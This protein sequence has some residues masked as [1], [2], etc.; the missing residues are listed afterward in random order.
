MTG[1]ADTNNV[2]RIFLQIGL[3]GV[4]FLPAFLYS[5]DGD[6][7]DPARQ[8]MA[9]VARGEV[10]AVQRDQG[11]LRLSAVEAEL[12]RMSPETI[13]KYFLTREKTLTLRDPAGLES[14][15]F[16]CTRVDVETAV[17]A[18]GPRAI[19]LTGIFQL[20]PEGRGRIT[21]GFMAGLYRPVPDYLPPIRFSPDPRRPHREIRHSV[22]HKIMI[23]V[24]DDFAVIGQGSDPESDNFNPYFYDRSPTVTPR[25]RAFYLDKYE[26]T[27]A[28]YYAFCRKTGRALPPAWRA[29]GTAYPPGTGDHPVTVASY[30][31]AEAYARWSGKR[32]PTETEWEMAARGGLGTLVDSSG[33]ES[34][35][36]SPPVYPYGS[37]FNE[38]LCNTLEAGNNATIPVT[39]TKDVSPYGI[40]GM[41]GNAREWTSDWYGPY[42]G[43]R[44]R[45]NAAS[46]KQFKVIRGGSYHQ[47]Q[48]RARSDARDYGGFPTLDADRTAG[49]R[50]VT[51]V[52]Q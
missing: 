42:P 23:Y 38:A 10:I 29:Q 36:K 28:E 1:L 8:R 19:T 4:V 12:A 49:F 27:N 41:C 31:D 51:E 33:E 44:L 25:I 3:V 30:R 6:E 21:I 20:N 45:K 48:E 7:S 47:A 9:F 43:H 22:D 37:T 15:T 5:G 18:G 11:A 16:T 14:G 26:V 34:V 17:R 39:E 52:T 46:G 32:L 35:K 13:R 24:P 40:Y 50:L 2:Q